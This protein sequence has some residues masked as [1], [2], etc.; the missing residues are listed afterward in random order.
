MLPGWIEEVERAWKSKRSAGLLADLKWAVSLY[1]NAPKYDAVMTGFERAAWLFALMRRVTFTRTP[2]HVFL[3]AH[4]ALP[5]AG[6]SRA[7][8]KWLFKQTF[9]SADCTVT[10]SEKQ[11]QLWAET[12]GVPAVRFKTVPYW[13]TAAGLNHVSEYGGYIFAGGDEERDYRTLIEAVRGTSY[14]LTIAA[15]RRDHF[16]GIEIPANVQIVT[17]KHAEFVKLLA[18]ASLVVVP[19]RAETIRFAGQ[20][21]YLNAMMY[22]KP[23]IVADAGAEEYIDNGV[24]G[25]IVRPGDPCE[26]RAAI[27]MIMRYPEVAIKVGKNAAV[28]ALKFTPQKYFNAVLAEASGSTS[29]QEA[30]QQ[31]RR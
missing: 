5:P 27:D 2:R 14:Q 12:F 26:L 15:L 31:A 20:Q 9:L 17:V 24:T 11:R 28:S 18:G 3:D 22:G 8:R 6:F 23:V 21:T 10:F 13:A 4:P 1:L 29:G 25:L 19:L 16:D 30:L 7:I